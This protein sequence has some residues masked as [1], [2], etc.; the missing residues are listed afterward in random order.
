MIQKNLNSA[1]EDNNVKSSSDILRILHIDDDKDFLYL[2]KKF[3]EQIS[4]GKVDVNSLSDS[5]QSLDVVGANN[6]DVIVCDYKMPNMDGLELLS[7]LKTQKSE[8][9]FIMFTGRGREEV[10]IKAL[11]LGAEYYIKKEGEPESQFRELYHIIQ[12]VVAHRRM[13][14][15]LRESERRF[16][17]FAELLPETVFEVD[18]EM[19]IVFVNNFFLEEFGYEQDEINQDLNALQMVAPENHDIVIKAFQNILKKEYNPPL[20]ILARRKDG[21]T[22][23]TLTFSNAILKKDEP[24]GLIGIMVDI[25]KLKKYEFALLESEQKYRT[26]FEESPIGILTCDLEGNIDNINRYALEFLKSPSKEATKAINLLTFP[27]LIKV[28]FSANLQKCINE[29]QEVSFESPYKTKWGK[30]GYF[31]GK[32]VPIKKNGEVTS[33]FIALDDITK[34]KEIE[35]ELKRQK[36]EP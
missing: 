33:V 2:T 6:I 29:K 14:E 31:K 5:E 4:E 22:F 16:R 7:K 26:L 32:M 34:Q 28:G 12:R 11:N 25:S 23:P 21:S 30:V 19:N 10:A 1:K 35:K 15:N 36:E 18:K 13:E 20:E 27:P 8:I 9:P 17:E 24:V 3:L